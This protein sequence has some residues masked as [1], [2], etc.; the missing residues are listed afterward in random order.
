MHAPSKPFR[1]YSAD[2]MMQIIDFLVANHELSDADALGMTRLALIL[3]RFES[4][5]YDDI[6]AI[7]PQ[8]Y[9]EIRSMEASLPEKP[10]TDT[11]S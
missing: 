11:P 6:A 8:S 10:A 2:E 1:T 7:A 9:R 4:M 5:P 3:K